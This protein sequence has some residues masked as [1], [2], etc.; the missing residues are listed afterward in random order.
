MRIILICITIFFTPFALGMLTVSHFSLNLVAGCTIY[1]FRGDPIKVFPGGLCLFRP[2]GE[3]ASMSATKL[4]YFKNNDELAWS[5]ENP[6][7][8]H[9]VNASNVESEILVMGSN[10][11]M[12]EGLL[13]RNDELLVIDS[14][15]GKVLKKIE[16]DE[17]IKQMSFKPLGDSK[18]FPAL[19]FK[20]KLESSHFNSFYQ[21]PK[22]HPTVKGPRWLKEG[23]YIANSVGLGVFIFDND[24]KNVVHHLVIPDAFINS[25]HDVQVTPRGTLIA[26]VNIILTKDGGRYSS[27]VEIDIPTNK[28]I[29]KIVGDPNTFFFSERCGGVQDLGN[30]E[31][32]FSHNFAGAYLYSKKLKKI[33]F[34]NYNVF[35]N[36][37]RLIPLQQVKAFDMRSFF[38]NRKSS[39]F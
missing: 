31:L 11:K 29:T 24:L 28:I 16:S 37:T 2:N 39:A 8:H 35:N 13:H 18:G 14:K 5:I 12:I 25:V 32:F 20:T 4:Q 15:D 30:D 3:F 34:S 21:I 33:T 23:N 1:T 9:Q 36:G 26:F 27:V 17:I 10:E 19:K 7:F 6:F 38:K 22:L